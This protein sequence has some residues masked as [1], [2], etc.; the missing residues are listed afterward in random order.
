M[1]PTDI[2]GKI[3]LMKDYLEQE[4]ASEAIDLGEEVLGELNSLKSPSAENEFP[5]WF[6]AVHHNLACAYSMCKKRDPIYETEEPPLHH[7]DPGCIFAPDPELVVGYRSARHRQ[8][9]IRIAKENHLHEQQAI[10]EE[11]SGDTLTDYL[12]FIQ[13][14]VALD[15]EHRPLLSR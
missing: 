13:S 6:H 2:T 8:E 11:A 1:A 5:L 4:K 15:P 9:A 12:N 7:T 14:M 10:T 3:N